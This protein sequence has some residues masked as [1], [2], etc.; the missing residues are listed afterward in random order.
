MAHLAITDVDGARFEFAERLDR[1]VLGLAGADVDRYHV[2]NGTWEVVREADG[3]HRLS[4]SSEAVGLDLTLEESEP[5]VAHG[6][7]G[8]SQKGSQ[9][10]NATHYY[11]LTRMATTGALRLGDETFEVAGASWMDHEFGTSVLESG[12]RGWDWFSLQLDD[13][14]E[15]MVFQL[16]REDGSRDPR[17]AGT[18]VGPA[19]EQTAL[20]V[21]DFTLV[22]GARWSSDATRAQYPIAWQLVIPSRGLELSVRALVPNQELTTPGSTGV[23]YWEGAVEVDGLARGRRLG[24]RGYL[25]MTGYAGQPMSAVL[26]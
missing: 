4:A 10:G 5:A 6:R 1:G 12:Q 24:G 16:R 3:R 15:L 14:S 8:F 25:E 7:A 18:L 26:R 17:S 21:G 19:G 2:W 9:V 13:G 23:T 11:S 22:P 20:A